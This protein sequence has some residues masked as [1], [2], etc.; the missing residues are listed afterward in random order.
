MFL[1]NRL[2]LNN[3]DF[4]L[5][6]T[7]APAEF[8]LMSLGEGANA[9]QPLFRIQSAIVYVRRVKVSPHILMANEERLNSENVLY[10]I[11]HTELLTYTIASGTHSHNKE[12][13]FR[14]LMPKLL[15]VGLTSNA[16]IN[17]SLKTNPFRF[18]HHN[19]NKVALYREGESVPGQPFT[20]DYTNG[21]YTREYLNLF[22]GLMR[23]NTNEDMGIGYNE[24]ASAYCL[25][26]FNLCPDMAFAGHSQYRRSGSLRLEFNFS[27]ATRTTL[28]AVVMGVFDGLNEI[29]KHRILYSDLRE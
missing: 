13:I 16:A 22:V 2:L 19:V 18:G 1:Q 6:L 29:N 11:Q 27:A 28:N 8:H 10:P 17:G 14:G 5:K 3:T 20:P 9:V 24:F 4:R 25:Y 23:Y 12:G 7:R 21:N 15:I 26:A